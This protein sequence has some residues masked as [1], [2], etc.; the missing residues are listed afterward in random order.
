M[1]KISIITLIVAMLIITAC[2]GGN[3]QTEISTTYIGGSEGIKLEFAPDA[4]PA[5]TADNQ[6]QSFDIAVQL[7]NKGEADVE[8]EDAL[9]TIKGFLPEAFGKS[10]A[11]LEIN[12]EEKM[13]RRI[14]TPEGSIIEPPYVEAIVENLEYQS[15]EPGNIQLPIRAELCYLYE[16][17]IATKL[18]IKEDMLKQEEDDICKINDNRAFSS[19][20]APVQVTKVSQSGAGREKTRFTFTVANVNTG[21][22]Y[23]D[24]TSCAP[25]STDDNKVFVE[26]VNLEGADVTCTGLQGGSESTGYI[27]LT[28]GT[29]R[30]VTCT[31]TF[32]EDQRTDRLQNFGIRLM[33]NYKEYIEQNIEIVYTPED[34]E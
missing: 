20:G 26:I 23:R 29:P 30:D 14:R 21:K 11:D 28:G 25:S 24:H 10:K 5:Q 22:V 2:S 34:G 18:C 27:T 3:N 16:T 1:K 9:V 12:P 15:S 13:E 33:Y 6:Q 7:T 32:A 4:P 19:S 17:N 31:A 8:P